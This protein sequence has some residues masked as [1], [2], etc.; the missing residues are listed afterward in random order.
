MVDDTNTCMA[1]EVR[2]ARASSMKTIMLLKD[3][4][5]QVVNGINLPTRG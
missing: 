4:D 3:F 1:K 2:P 5:G